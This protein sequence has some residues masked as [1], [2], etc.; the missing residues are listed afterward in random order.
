MTAQP[1]NECDRDLLEN[2]ETVA[3]M[4]GT[5]TA[6][7]AIVVRVREQMGVRLDWHYCG[8]RACI[9]TSEPVE[10]HREIR[11]NLK[12]AIPVWLSGGHDG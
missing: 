7:E 5:S 3:V 12:M 6:I 4:A 2:G 10:K 1:N 9:L 8:G 11:E